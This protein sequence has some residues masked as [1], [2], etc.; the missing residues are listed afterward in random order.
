MPKFNIF[1]IIILSS[2][3]SVLNAEKM[4]SKNMKFSN[5]KSGNQYINYSESQEKSKN[6]FF[7]SYTSLSSEDGLLNKIPGSGLLKEKNNKYGRRFFGAGFGF[8]FDYYI[9]NNYSFFTF[10]YLPPFNFRFFINELFSLDIKTYLIKTIVSSAL[11][12]GEF[13]IELYP[14]FNKCIAG[15]AYLVGSLGIGTGYLKFNNQRA[16]GLVIPGKLGFEFL[17]E[18]KNIGI[19]VLLGMGYKMVFSDN[20][21]DIFYIGFDLQFNFYVIKKSR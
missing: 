1:I 2:G 6:I 4:Y 11:G 16:V 17:N 12:N 21:T 20:F 19:S 10:V 8:G 9:K 13:Q 5:L 7:E 15:N 18:K 14:A 3:F